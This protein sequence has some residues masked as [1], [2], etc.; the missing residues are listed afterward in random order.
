M[1]M[2]P[3]KNIFTSSYIYIFSSFGF[4]DRRVEDITGN[5]MFSVHGTPAVS[6]ELNGTP[7]EHFK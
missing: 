4:I 5:R 7:E 6:T 3:L 2:A 1:Y